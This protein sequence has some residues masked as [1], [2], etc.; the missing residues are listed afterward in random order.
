MQED[1]HKGS[2][3]SRFEGFGAAPSEDLW[4]AISANLDE[5]KKRR[6]VF[7]IW[8]GSGMAAIF[9]IGLFI[10]NS[11]GSDAVSESG[12]YSQSNDVNSSANNNEIENQTETNYQNIDNQNTQQQNDNLAENPDES[13]EQINSNNDTANSNANDQNESANESTDLIANGNNSQSDNGRGNDS[14]SDNS[15]AVNTNSNGVDSIAERSFY[16]RVLLD[17]METNDPRLLAQNLNLPPKPAAD[18][19]NIKRKKGKWEMGLG[20]MYYITPGSLS[21]QDVT[22]DPVTNFEGDTINSIEGFDASNVS[23][24][25]TVR[26]TIGLDFHVGYQINPRLRVNSGLELV[27]THYGEQIITT[28]T[29]LESFD[30]QNTNVRITSI[31]IP[32]TLD[33]ALIKKRRFELSL[34]TGMINSIPIHQGGEPTSFPNIIPSENINNLIS[35]Y[36][37]AFDLNLGARYRLL[38]KLSVY[39]NPDLRWFFTQKI[40]SNYDLP[41]RRTWIGA[42]VGLV[43]DL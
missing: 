28:N 32:L 36:A 15:I 14:S 34:G 9:V 23:Q 37:G 3:Q 20:V 41:N 30:T 5:K 10:F 16:D 33:F 21:K 42:S 38:P 26:Q 35:G 19:S 24:T 2:L 6:G 4:G 29:A 25:V 18:I 11:T 1:K 7:W 12:Q 17:L 8:F 39:A 22:A 27:R 13:A 31:N 40:N 43:W